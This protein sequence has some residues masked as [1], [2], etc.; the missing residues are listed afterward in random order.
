MRSGIKAEQSADE[1]SGYG[2]DVREL[3]LSVSFSVNLLT[4]L[5]AKAW[6]D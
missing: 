3:H 4:S 1:G 2:N 6:S 5:F